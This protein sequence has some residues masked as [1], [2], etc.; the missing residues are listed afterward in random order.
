MAYRSTPYIGM[1]P[2]K[3]MAASSFSV[4]KVSTMSAH[5]FSLFHHL[6]NK[7]KQTVDREVS[8]VTHVEIVIERSLFKPTPSSS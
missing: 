2:K 6:Y 5:L 7:R 4:S 8:H 3:K 1:A